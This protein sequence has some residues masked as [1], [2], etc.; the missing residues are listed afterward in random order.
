MIGFDIGGT[1]CAVSVGEECDGVLHITDKRVMPTDLA[2]SPDVMI[3]RMCAAAEEMTADFS[4]IGI[5]CG[6]PLDAARGVILSPP[7]LPG[8]D[9]VEIV[10]ILHERYGGYVRLQCRAR[11]VAGEYRRLRRAVLRAGMC[12]WRI[13]RSRT[14]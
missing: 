4:Q 8:W 14:K 12:E 13:M 11:R 6:G 9:E 5:S 2:V 1:K 7:N 3:A 10:R